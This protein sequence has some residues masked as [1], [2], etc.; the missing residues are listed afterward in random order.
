MK[1]YT[2][3]SFLR[4]VGAPVHAHWSALVVAGGLLAG[5]IK[6][7][8]SALTIICSYFGVILLHESGH[9]YFAQRLGCRPINIYLSFIH[10]VCE[11]QAPDSFKDECI[12]AWGGVSAQLV[13]AIPLIVLA[14]TTSLSE[15]PILGILMV[16]L[17]YINILIAIVNLAPAKGLDGAIAWRLIPLLIKQ[18]RRKTASK[19]I[20]KGHIRRVK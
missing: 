10:G 2:K 6:E 5:S 15:L 1:G 16:F 20:A 9:A 12:I 13:V 4:I 7:P 17:G 8:F 3:L 14:Q 19:K 11:Y 18:R